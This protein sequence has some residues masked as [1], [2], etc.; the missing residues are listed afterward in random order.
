MPKSYVELQNK[1]FEKDIQ[2]MIDSLSSMNIEEAKE[3][4]NLFAN[5]ADIY[6]E[7]YDAQGE[8]ICAYGDKTKA[9]RVIQAKQ[10]SIQSKGILHFQMNLSEI[11]MS[12]NINFL[13]LIKIINF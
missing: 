7:L 10:L 2:N 4:L 12:M 1:E 8:F 6:A 13:S 11:S 9:N 3:V 5:K